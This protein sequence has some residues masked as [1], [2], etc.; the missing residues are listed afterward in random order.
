M[1]GIQ[2]GV[3]AAAPT[4]GYTP[5]EPPPSELSAKVSILK[6]RHPELVEESA[7]NDFLLL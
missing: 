4:L 6:F 1:A 5:R 2:P 3:G 7:S